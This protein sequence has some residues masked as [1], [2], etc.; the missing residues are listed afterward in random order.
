MKNITI[1]LTE[2]AARWARVRAAELDT[3]VSRLVGDLL[4][5]MMRQEE[6]YRAAMR[7]ALTR[8]HARISAQGTRYPTR[9]ELHD[10][11][12]LR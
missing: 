12:S 2:D 11:N 8:T 7:F 10:R 1:T 5:D 9:D 6:G 4:T 3:S